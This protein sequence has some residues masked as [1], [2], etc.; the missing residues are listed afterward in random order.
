MACEVVVCND[1]EDQP[2]C[3][4]LSGEDVDFMLNRSIGNVEMENDIK[5]I[6]PV[7]PWQSSLSRWLSEEE[8]KNLQKKQEIVDELI[9]QNM[10]IYGLIDKMRECYEKKRKELEAEG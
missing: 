8:M 4:P 6:S 9:K 5:E 10:H 2:S 7:I 1:D 3:S